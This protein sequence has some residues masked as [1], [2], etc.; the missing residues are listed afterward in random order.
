MREFAIVL[1]GPTAVGKTDLAIEL[2]SRFPVELISVD[3]A[4]VYRQMDIGTGKPSAEILRQFPHHLVNILDPIES[5]SAGQ[6]VRDVTVLINDIHSRGKV[7]LLVG[8]TMLYFRAMLR[9]IADMP[10]ADAR[11]RAELDQRAANVGWP[12]IHAELQ[13]LDPIVAQ[14]IGVND[15]QRIQ[16]ALEVMELTGRTMSDIQAD[17]RPALPSVEFLILGL[18]MNREQ[19][20]SRIERRF[21]HMMNAGFLAEVKRLFQ[22]NDLNAN[23]PSMRAVGYR[24]LWAHLAGQ[25]TLDEAIA[26]GILATRHLA[27]RQLIWMRAAPDLHWLDAGVHSPAD[28]AAT[29]IKKI[30]G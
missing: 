12:A 30:F 20:Y 8:G 14:R 24:Q 23:L 16:R 4:L 13:Q 10:E 29:L 27:R 21:M 22:R 19:L 6:F 26:Q 25:C 15:A 11:F 18:N 3:S 5:Y 2:A 9:G 1:M 7:P 28:Q 17:A